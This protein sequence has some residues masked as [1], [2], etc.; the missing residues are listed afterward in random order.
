MARQWHL[1]FHLAKRSAPVIAMGLGSTAFAY[2][3][4]AVPR[5]RSAYTAAAV[6][7]ALALPHTVLL[8]T[9]TNTE[10][11]ARAA[12]AEGRKASGSQVELQSESTEALVRTWMKW[13]Y[14]RSVYALAAAVLGCWAVTA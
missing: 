9:P 3:A 7:P 2:L 12:A 8:L 6:L 10:L 11:L 4:Y 14:S 1:L 5:L 13:N